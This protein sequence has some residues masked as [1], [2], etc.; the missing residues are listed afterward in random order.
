MGFPVKKMELKTS[1]YKATELNTQPWGSRRFEI[2][3]V[4]DKRVSCRGRAE[5]FKLQCLI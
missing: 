1:V 4:E 2:I 5:G 3:L